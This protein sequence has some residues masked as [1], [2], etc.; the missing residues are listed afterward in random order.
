MLFHAWAMFSTS[1]AID[2]WQRPLA[3][4][5][6]YGWMGVDLFFVLS[7]YLIGSQVL[8]TLHQGRPFSFVDF[9]VRR[10]F[11]ILP[12]YLVVLAVYFFWPRFS[13]SSGIQP[14]WQFLTFTLNLLIDYRHNKA[15]SHAWSLCVEE[16]FYILFPLLA[17]WLIRRAS[18]LKFIVVAAGVMLGGMA[19][20]DW[21]W[22]H[23]LAPVSAD[24]DGRFGLRFLEDIYFPTWTRLDGLLAGVALATIKIYRLPLWEKLQRR[25]GQIALAGLLVT[26][27]AVALFV[28][29][30]GRLATTFGYPLLSL[31]F[32]LLVLAASGTRGWLATL[33]LP[34]ARWIATISYSLYLSHKG[35]M[36]MLG[37]VLPPTV[38]GHDVLRVAI[39]VT[40]VLCA[41][42]LLYY[43]VE[44][45]FLRLR[46][47]LA[48]RRRSNP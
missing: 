14:L 18:A 23:Q 3:A 15:F 38:A 42:A 46:D 1:F 29:R 25:P 13:E 20:R 39:Y 19:L 10:A 33:R 9:Y 37:Q 4:V 17:W 35:I 34:G 40:A 30:S 8:K 47:A 48:A 16:H 28:D 32:A 36:H 31:G 6:S 21:I 41:G 11:R 43:G 7:G 45:P 26:L 27:A 12:A 24:A 2:V 22:V 44:Q 5:Q